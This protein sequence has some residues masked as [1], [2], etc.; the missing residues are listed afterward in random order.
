MRPLLAWHY[1]LFAHTSDTACLFPSFSIFRGF[2]Q[3]VDNERH[4]DP[5]AAIR[6]GPAE[7]ARAGKACK[8]AVI[9]VGSRGDGYGLTKKISHIPQ[10]GV[11]IIRCSRSPS[12]V[13]AGVRS[14]HS[15]GRWGALLC[16]DRVI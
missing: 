9:S 14:L 16:A 13:L 2:A 1:D 6:L 10:S 11:T 15:I 7:G 3:N 5:A 4:G 8:G 12:K